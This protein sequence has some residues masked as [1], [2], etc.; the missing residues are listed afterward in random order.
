MENIIGYK[1]VKADTSEG[2]TYKVSNLL[3]EGWQPVGSA[4]ITS[5]IYEHEITTIYFYQTVFKYE[6]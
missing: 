3:E 6:E 2:I 5:K 4:F 1:V